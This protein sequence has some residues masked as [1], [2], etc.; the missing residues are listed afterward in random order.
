MNSKRRAV[1]AIVKCGDKILIGK[2]NDGAEGF[3][4]IG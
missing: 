1:I 4:A 3:L 2:K